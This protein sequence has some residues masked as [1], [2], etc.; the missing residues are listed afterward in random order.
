MSRYALQKQARDD[1]DFDLNDA[2]CGNGCI[3]GGLRGESLPTFEWV[4]SDLSKRSFFM[5]I[6]FPDDLAPDVA[7]L[8]PQ[9]FEGK[10]DICIL[11]G[12]LQHETDVI[13]AV[14]GCPFNS[15]FDVTMR[16]NRHPGGIFEVLDGETIEIV[17]DPCITYSSEP[18]IT[19]ERNGTHSSR[20]V[21]APSSFH[22]S[23]SLHYDNF[24]LQCAGK[25]N[26]QRAK[27]KIHQIVNRASSMFGSPMWQ[28]GHKISLR[29]K[30]I[31]H[32]NEN[33]Q[34]R[35]K[36]SGKTLD[37][38]AKKNKYRKQSADNYHYFSCDNRGGPSGVAWRGT[39]C[40]QSRSSRTGISEWIDYSNRDDNYKGLQTALTFAHELGHS[41]NMPHD[42][43]TDRKCSSG[44][45]KNY[46][47]KDRYGHKCWNQGSIMD[48]GQKPHV[49]K[50]SRCSVESMNKYNFHCKYGEYGS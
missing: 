8:I 38:I 41:L 33:L 28:L 30:E 16:S 3:F 15:T 49:N 18:T 1:S 35:G 43:C 39:I 37:Y 6:D 23:L 25:G 4:P 36:K 40:S 11:Q 47:R 31:S 9:Q 13:I 26:H 21:G 7:V 32:V 10:E 22:V 34:L 27:N 17:Q 12:F 5:K 19:L 2:N 20:A 24:F 45:K 46:P 14:N 44:K 42:F 29:V 48:Y 50:W